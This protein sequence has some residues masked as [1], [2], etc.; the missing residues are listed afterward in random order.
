MNFLRMN[1]HR[2]V[3]AGGLGTYVLFFVTACITLMSLAP[4]V[5]PAL[6]ATKADVFGNS[7]LRFEFGV[8][9]FPVIIVNITV[10][11]LI[12][13]YQKNKIKSISVVHR[14]FNFEVSKRIALVSM[15]ILIITYV[16]SS[17]GELFDGKFDSDYY[18]TL[19]PW[20]ESFNFLSLPD[21]QLNRDIGHHI[22]ISLEILSMKAF[23]NYKVI[24]YLATIALLIMIYL[25]VAEIAK[26]RFAG[27]ISTIL[28]MQSGVFLFYDTSVSYTNLWVLFFLTSLYLIIKKWQ[29]SPASF[30]L[31]MFSKGLTAVFLPISILFAYRVRT[32][33][34]N[35]LLSYIVMAI[36]VGGF[37]LVTGA[38]LN[39]TNTKKFSPSS[40]LTGFTAFAFEF[41][42]DVIIASFLLPVI[43]GLFI[44]SKKKNLYA[45]PIMLV[46]ATMLISGPVLSGTS[47]HQ[48]VP[49]RFI[50]IVVFFAI[51]IGLFFSK[52][53]SE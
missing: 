28:T 42:H 40:F 46:L 45:D 43:V 1:I 41:R 22:Q 20:L 33:S 30:V 47:D 3:A 35:V 8:L 39:P 29:I 10:L 38:S 37:L 2:F 26:K 53:A 52:R 17:E 51:S 5:F 13:L 4:A 24:P 15:A 18:G 31:G 27:I 25:F 19:K 14:I 32:P 49:Y 6:F 11:T 23:G 50:P 36:V 21:N 48:N 16:V 12:T 44:L 34:R 7:T 9:A